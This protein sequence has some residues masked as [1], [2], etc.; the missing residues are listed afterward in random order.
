MLLV[1]IIAYFVTTNVSHPSDMILPSVWKGEWGIDLV[2]ES[3]RA[4]MSQR[5]TRG[6]I[7]EGTVNRC[8]GYGVVGAAGHQRTTGQGFADRREDVDRLL[9][10]RRYDI[11]ESAQSPAPPSAVRKPPAT[12][13]LTFTIR[14]SR[15]ARLLSN[16][17]RK[18]CMKAKV[19]AL[20]SRSRS[21]RFNGG[22]LGRAS[23]FLLPSPVAGE[24]SRVYPARITSS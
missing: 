3:G 24:D 16:G 7:P 19:S 10:G 12:F 21:S 4:G 6:R 17:T 22:G 13:C 5:P 14:T 2:K 1:N 11:P 23:A 20:K 8:S 18:S 9:A 15:S